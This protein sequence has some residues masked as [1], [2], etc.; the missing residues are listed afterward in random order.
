MPY[1]SISTEFIGENLSRHPSTDDPTWH[2]WLYQSAEPVQSVWCVSFFLTPKHVKLSI[3][4]NALKVVFSQ[5]VVSKIKWNL[6]LCS[7]LK[8]YFIHQNI[9]QEVKNGKVIIW[10]QITWQRF[11]K[12]YPKKKTKIWIWNNPKYTAS[13]QLTICYLK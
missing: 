4:T 10:R 9:D 7:L 11:I 5:L 1:R 12:I 3:A 2:Y 8:L 6:L 13:L